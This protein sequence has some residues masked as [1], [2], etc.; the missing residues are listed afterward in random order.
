M[1]FNPLPEIQQSW[2]DQIYD[3]LC[4]HYFNLTIRLASTD[5]KWWLYDAWGDCVTYYIKHVKDDTPVVT[6]FMEYYKLRIKLTKPLGG[7][8]AIVY[9]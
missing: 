6:D 8:Y 7:N 2:R 1:A 3:L 9:K 4:L 5:K